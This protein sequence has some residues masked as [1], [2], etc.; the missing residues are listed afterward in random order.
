MKHIALLGAGFSRNWGGWLADEAFG[1]LIGSP[2]AQADAAIR[3]ALLRR[4]DIGGFEA[5]LSDIQA[6]YLHNKGASEKTSLD[7]F[8][9]AINSMF[10]DMDS[11]FAAQHLE[12]QNDIAYMVR[13]FL[14]QFDA[15]Y[16]L[17]QD[18]LPELC[19]LDDN[20]QFGSAGKWNGW[21]L[22]GMRPIPDPTRHPLDRAPLLW[23]PD[24]AHL[25]IAGKK[26][27]RSSNSTA[28]TTG[29]Q[30]TASAFLYWAQINQRQFKDKKS[31]VGISNCLG[32]R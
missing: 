21:Q 23:T 13:T 29:L 14:I 27:S 2:E 3:T 17:N 11:G 22:P 28:R 30:M 9:T 12:F 5:A 18:C 31:Y 1:H 24:R 19:Y 32:L 8:Q 26:L 6:A 4:K 20:I 7:R 10:S 15:I 25:A 16:S